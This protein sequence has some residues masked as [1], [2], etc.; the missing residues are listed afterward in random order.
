MH[1]DQTAAGP[2]TAELL[3]A[4]TRP[5]PLHALHLAETEKA[6]IRL[7]IKRDDLLHPLYGGNKWRKLKYNLQAFQAGNYAS[8]LTFGGAWSNHI[9]ATAA[10]GKAAGIST[11][12]IIRGEPSSSP[13]ATLQFA[14]DCG[15][16]L[17][18]INRQQ[19]RRLSEPA[20]IE[21]L[22]DRLGLHSESV[23]V[24][25]E[26][27]SNAL[28]TKGCMEIIRELQVQTRFDE[29]CCSMGT[30]ATLA[31]MATAIHAMQTCVDGA[32]TGSTGETRP[33]TRQWPGTLPETLP[34]LTGFPAINPGHDNSRNTTESW[35]HTAL[36]RNVEELLDHTMPDNTTTYSKTA[37]A[38][39]M[40]TD[41]HFGGYAKV[42]PALVT[43]INQVHDQHGILFDAVY[44]GKML[45]GICDRAS[46]GAYQRGTTLVA[47]HS[48]G[49][50]GNHGFAHLG[51]HRLARLRQQAQ[52]D[53]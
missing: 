23:Y 16:Q 22:L 3:L 31:G 12:G 24:L 37:P 9:H 20:F 48:G 21:G 19:Y 39:N 40:D 52:A 17:H 42:T 53:S 45:Y 28:A 33:R 15:M 38:W 11:I 30:G 35:R 43:F 51:L 50:Q 34:R 4:D 13:S 32:S 25:P 27:G 41:Y 10:A 18:F 29:V 46:K 44:T 47:I 2:I 26:G 6:G 7:L 49:V 5:S 8:L 1:D 14:A 36:A